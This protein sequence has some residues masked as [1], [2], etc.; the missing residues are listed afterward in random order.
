MTWNQLACEQIALEQA[1]AVHDVSRMLRGVVSNMHLLA[2]ALSEK[3]DSRPMSVMRTTF[4]LA[5]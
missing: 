1:H 5:A 2:T 4:L 3:Q